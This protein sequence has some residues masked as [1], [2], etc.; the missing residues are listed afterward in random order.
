MNLNLNLSLEETN[1][2]LSAL[3]KQPYEV[4]AALVNKIQEQA[5]PQLNNGKENEN[6]ANEVV[7]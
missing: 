4:V 3:V 6:Q 2:V 7:E 5:R 1:I